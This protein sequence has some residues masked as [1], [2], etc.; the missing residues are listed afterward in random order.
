MLLSFDMLCIRK[1]SMLPTSCVL[2]SSRSASAIFRKYPFSQNLHLQGLNP[3]FPK[4]IMIKCYTRSLPFQYQT[5]HFLQLGKT[6]SQKSLLW[7]TSCRRQSGLQSC[8]PTGYCKTW[9]NPGRSSNSTSRSGRTDPCRHENQTHYR[10][11]DRHCL[12]KN[13]QLAQGT[14]K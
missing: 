5:W 4:F 2:S 11:S 3:H 10:D 12:Y 9:S 8:F 13:N 7:N 6:A 1:L 14:C